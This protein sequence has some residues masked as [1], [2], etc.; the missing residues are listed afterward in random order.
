MNVKPND[1]ELERL[2]D[3]KE[4]SQDQSREDMMDMLQSKDYKACCFKVR[5]Q[6]IGLGN[7]YAIFFSYFFLFISVIYYNL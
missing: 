4:Y 5:G 3:T 6:S 2:N 7:I 1:I